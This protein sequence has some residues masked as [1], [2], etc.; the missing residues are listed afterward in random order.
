MTVV[1]TTTSPPMMS[2]NG[3]QNLRT[4]QWNQ[5]MMITPCRNYCSVR[6]TRCT[7]CTSHV[8][9]HVL[10]SFKCRSIYLSCC[11]TCMLSSLLCVIRT[12]Q[13]DFCLLINFGGVWE[14]VLFT[15]VIHLWRRTGTGMTGTTLNITKC[16]F[17]PACQVFNN[18]FL[19]IANG[20]WFMNISKH[21]NYTH[22]HT[23][24]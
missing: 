20:R 12:S 13:N 16:V 10:N 2:V 3:K 15:F 5:K 4:L 7:G 22:T 23:C 9:A 21:G 17:K 14:N 19:I 8:K 18:R 11:I 1:T 24:S 6:L